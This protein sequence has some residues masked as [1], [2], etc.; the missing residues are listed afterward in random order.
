ML[1]ED[2]SG[3]RGSP[4]EHKLLDPGWPV[5]EQLSP[6]TQAGG[7]GP[8]PSLQDRC[9][10]FLPGPEALSLSQPDLVSRSMV[11]PKTTA[12]CLLPLHRVTGI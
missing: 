11:T 10:S 1:A 2:G 6:G 12:M 9:L 8:S 3:V 5:L 4:T 7:R